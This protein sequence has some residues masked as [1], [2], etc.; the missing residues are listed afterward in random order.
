[1]NPGEKGAGRLYGIGVGPGDPE[2]IT[3]RAHRLLSEVPVIFVPQKDSQSGSY[4]E[5][6]IASLVENSPERVIRLIFPML[7]DERRLASSRQKAAGV[8]W[9][10]LKKGDDCA[11][12]NVGDPL[13]YGTFIHVLEELRKN[14]PEVEVEV[15]P[16][17][18]SINAAAA[19]A[20]VP[21]AVNDQRIAIISGDDDEAI[22]ETLKNFDT[23]VFMKLPAMFGRL[24][25]I[26]EEMNLMAKCVYVSRCTTRDEEI[27][28]DIR[29]LKGKKLDYFSLLIV[30][31]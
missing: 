8:I 30:R 10:H 31:R 29:K 2:L 25:S 11:L 27:V 7:K 15:V 4:A 12:V 6:I 26:L 17:V 5:S 21:L 3:L 18:S 1:M 28:T 23:V 24:L 13:L 14:H 20:V 16:G 22:M 9:Q 19:R